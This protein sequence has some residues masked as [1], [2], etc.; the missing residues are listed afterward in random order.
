MS[1]HAF[2]PRP[3]PPSLSPLPFPLSPP[4]LSPPLS[5]S[6]SLSPSPPTPGLS[7][8]R[9]APRPLGCAE[10]RGTPAVAPLPLSPL[11][12][13][14]T[15]GVLRGGGGGRKKEKGGER[16]SP[17]ACV[18]WYTA[19]APPGPLRCVL[20]S[21]HLPSRGPCGLQQG[22][23]SKREP[24]TPPHTTHSTAPLSTPSPLLLAPPLSH[25]PNAH[26]HTPTPGNHPHTTTHVPAQGARLANGA[27]GKA[28]GKR[29]RF[30]GPKRLPT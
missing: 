17:C 30:Q 27:K 29:P 6:L 11:G 10:S 3:L 19:A 20:P 12:D 21:P 16:R 18:C 8:R 24:E 7:C 26:K 9:P 15:L 5:L 22:R 25:A 4:T 2:S 1:A 14:R 13:L 23:D 28:L